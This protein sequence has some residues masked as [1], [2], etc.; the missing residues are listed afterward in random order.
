MTWPRL[1]KVHAH[2]VPYQGRTYEAI[3]MRH[4]RSAVASH[5]WLIAALVQAYLRAWRLRP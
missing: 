4:H 2:W 1:V 5:R 3:F